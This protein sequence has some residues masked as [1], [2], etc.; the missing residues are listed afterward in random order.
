MKKFPIFILFMV[1]ASEAFSWGPTGHRATG[2]IAQRYL[3]KKAQREIERIL[4]GQSLAMAS[5]WM[6]EVRSDST[7]D[8]TSDWHWVTIPD[9]MTYEQSEKNKNGDVIQTIERLI[10]ELKSRKLTPIKEAENLKML[11]HLVGDIHQPLHVGRG[12]DR[13]GNN[14]RVMWFR[15]D[16]NLHR[17]WDADMIDDTKLSYTE[18]AES[19]DKPTAAQL[20]QWKKSRVRDWANESVAL[21]KKVYDY[22][23]EKFGYEYAYRNFPIVRDRLLQ[24]GVRLAMILNEIYGV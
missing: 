10:Q 11:V 24:A 22:K 14:I 8:F 23:N 4:N 16:S 13:G 1:V 7:Y 12:T 20:E 19:L 18:L 9:G 15:V 5:T 2:L 21:R 6:D 17:I 3:N